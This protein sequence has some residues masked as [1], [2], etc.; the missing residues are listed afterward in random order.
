MTDN[1]DPRF[2]HILFSGEPA[3]RPRIT[4]HP[5]SRHPHTRAPLPPPDPASGPMAW[6]LERA[7]LPPDCYRDVPLQR[8]APA[9]MRALRVK[10]VAELRH[11]IETR[12]E[13]LAVVIDALL[14]GVTSP[15]RD[16]PVFNH[17]AREVLPELLA[18][19]A[20]PCILSVGCSDGAEL[21]SMAMLLA[22]AGRLDGA[23]LL[24]IDCR[25]SAIERA[26]QGLLSAEARRAIPPALQ[27]RYTQ[28]APPGWQV[29][30]ELRASTTWEV[31]DVFARDDTAAWDM[32][33][34]RNVAIYLTAPAAE[35]LWR[36]LIQWL[37]PGGI[38]VTGKAE[39]PPSPELVRLAPC[40]YKAREPR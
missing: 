40:I 33:L 36:R 4:P 28:P 20:S 30:A 39:K 18:R 21:Y 35:R 3:R 8:R 38:L 12:P 24:G 31:A 25:V 19:C 23:R 13:L 5:A 16:E 10:S 9:C 2:R 11:A 1:A 17:L 29:A 27:A 14:I 7:G 15:F 22:E 6:L 34:C 32:V 37:R 26:R